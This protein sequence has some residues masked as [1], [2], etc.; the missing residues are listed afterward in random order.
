MKRHLADI[1]GQMELAISG[2]TAGDD[3]VVGEEE[4]LTDHFRL[5]TAATADR[6]RKA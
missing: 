5:V 4:A 2:G 6:A 1:L 3:E